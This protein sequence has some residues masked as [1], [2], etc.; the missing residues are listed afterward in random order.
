LD[1][2]KNLWRDRYGRLPTP[3]RHLLKVAAIRL[4]AAAAGIESVETEEN[5]L[6]LRRGGDFIMIGHR[7]PR[8][9]SC[10]PAL[11]LRQILTL[12][13]QL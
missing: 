6:R 10:D 2:L 7:H 1:N 8:L 3:A 13:Q 9:E 5:V 12:L 4:R 11:K